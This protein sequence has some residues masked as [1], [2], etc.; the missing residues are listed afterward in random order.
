MKITPPYVDP[1]IMLHGAVSDPSESDIVADVIGCCAVSSADGES[2]FSNQRIG[3]LPQMSTAQTFEVLED[4]KQAWNGGTGTWPQMSLKQRVEA[5]E[6]FIRELGS[7]REEIV[8]TLMWEIG[9][10]RKD[11]E[12]EF[13]RTVAFV[14]KVIEV[15]RTDEEFASSWTTVGSTKAFVRRAAI[16]IIMCLGPM[17]YPLNETYATLIPAL[18]MG[19]VAIMKIPTVGGLSHLLTMEAFLKALPP[20]AMNFVSGRGRETMP[21]LMETGDIDALAFIGGSNAA[22]DLIGKHPHPHRLK[23]F[24]QLEAK[25]MGIFLSDLFIESKASELSDALDQAVLG[26]LSFNGQRCTALKLFFIPDA[27]SETF[28]KMLAERVEA[29]SVGLPWQIWKAD[30]GS[31]AYSSITPL[32][33][34]KA[35][36]YMKKLIEDAV[37]KGAKIMNSGGGDIIGGEESTLMV[38]AVLYPVTEDMDVYFEEQFGPVV[39]VAKYD[40]IDTAKKVWS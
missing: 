40:S 12:A 17:N 18:L 8:T 24:L 4:A 32:P 2:V 7:K 5:I 29:K 21:P 33:N 9:K 10:N 30:D 26:A 31:E 11:A 15:I 37:L 23:V 16:G 22:D 39:P 36:N 20:G 28:A 19:N 25:N 1:K 35:V 27:H 38:P 3:E 34:K 13:D 6:L 14:Q